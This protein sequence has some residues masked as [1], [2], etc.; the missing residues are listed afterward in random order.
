MKFI[1]LLTRRADCSWCG[2]AFYLNRFKVKVR[3]ASPWGHLGAALCTSCSRRLADNLER[4]HHD[5]E[6]EAMIPKPRPVRNTRTKVARA[7]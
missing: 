1:G 7:G 5:L 2:D 3:A 4:Y 6:P